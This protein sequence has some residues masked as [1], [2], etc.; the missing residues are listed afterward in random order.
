[1]D[2]AL[3]FFQDLGDIPK[4]VHI[5]WKTRHILD[6]QNPIVLNGIKNIIDLNP[7]WRV[8]ISEDDDVEKYL[9]SSLSYR[10]YVLIRDRHIVE[11]IDLWRLLKIYNEG[12]LYTDLDRYHNIP[13]K[14]VIKDQTKCVLPMHRDIDFSQ[15]IML[16]APGNRIHEYAIELNLHRRRIGIQDILSLGPITYFHAATKVIYGRMLN[17]WPGKQVLDEI[18]YVI[19]RS[20]HVETYVEN[21]PEDLLTFRFNHATWRYGN[22]QSK[23][24]LYVESETEHWTISYPIDSNRPWQ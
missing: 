21:P 17:R 11:K 19:N 6:S 5:S 18:H 13:F 15:D 9:K 2:E 8:V 14:N 22:W 20:E 12:G 16:S 10:D 23:E 1:M 7:G 4:T 24:D 3:S